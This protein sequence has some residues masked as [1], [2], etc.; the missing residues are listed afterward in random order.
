[1]NSSVGKEDSGGGRGAA[2]G[3]AG[4]SGGGG[5]KAKTE[6]TS[7]CCSSSSSSSSPV[8]ITCAPTLTD[9]A[10]CFPGLF[11]EKIV[12][13]AGCDDAKTLSRLDRVSKLFHAPTQTMGVNYEGG[14]SSVKHTVSF[15]ER[16]LRRMSE[17]AGR[18]VRGV[19]LP[20]TV[21]GPPLP[22]WTQV[23]LRE[24][25]RGFWRKGGAAVDRAMDGGG[26]IGGSM[27][28]SLFVAADGSALSWGSGEEEYEEEY[29]DDGRLGHGESLP[30]T[31]VPKLIETLGGVR[32]CAMSTGGWHSLFLTEDGKVYSCGYGSCGRL[33]H[34][35]NE[36]HQHVPKLIEA[37]SGVRV[38]AV[39]AGSVHSLFL[40]E[41]GKVYSCGIGRD[42]RLGHGN[43][44][45][46]HV[47]KL[48][49]ALSGVRVCAVSAGG[50]YSLFLTEDGKVYSCGFG[51]Y[52]RLG[53]GNEEHQDV[54]KLIEALS[55]VRVCAVSAGTAHSL[56]LTEDGKAYSCGRGLYSALGHGN[57][58]HQYVPKL[59]EALS[60]VRVCAVSAGE[61]HSLV[62]AEDGKVY[63]C[64]DGEFGRLG[65]G[66]TQSQLVPKIIEALSG[67]RVCAVSAGTWH[68]LFLT[69]DG[70]LYSCGRGLEGQLGHGN[71]ERQYLPKR[72]EALPPVA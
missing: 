31:N 47:P 50:G 13:T 30:N 69:E 27:Q 39:S 7:C 18:G 67:V 58:E 41:D 34:G 33:G 23:L 22:N 4:Q 19:A 28:H 9:V 71:E 49:E 29:E 26:K 66:N 15:V 21:A 57:Q 2:G 12:L 65:H 11:L 64:G 52:G 14:G 25:R 68:S 16:A 63:S 42:G 55:G 48:I 56:F 45:H 44:E 46:Q 62:L 36:E 72:I 6:S 24:L 5:K 54:P 51:V 3:G 43:A 70:T 60:S 10:L 8:F 53:H 40:T 59:I 61:Y 35:Y 20:A 17:Q 32:V 37:L 38:C 1:M